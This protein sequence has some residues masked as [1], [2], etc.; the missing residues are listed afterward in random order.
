[1][2]SKAN[3]FVLITI[4]LAFKVSSQS[5]KLS[6]VDSVIQPRI[7]ASIGGYFPEVE[8][9]LRIDSENGLGTELSLEDN[10]RFER[11]MSVLKLELLYRLKNRSQF[12]FFYTALRRNSTYRLDADIQFGDTTFNIGAQADIFFNTYYYALTWRY[13]LFSNPNWNAGFSVGARYVEFKTGIEAKLNSNQFSRSTSIGAPVLL[14]GVHGAGY[15]TDKLLAR[16]R[17]E[18]FHI[19]VADINIKVVETQT[20][21]EYYIFENFG[22]GVAYSTNSYNVS[23]IPF[24]TRFKGKV[25]FDFGG[26]NLYATARF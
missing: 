16:Y 3:F 9:S 4:I 5:Y 1:M 14:V 24:T 17:M 12:S 18:Y 26:F 11:Q 8:T 20:S 6:D 21:L 7:Y 10:F 23:E 2:S 15:L 25:V 13:A 22:L 19:M